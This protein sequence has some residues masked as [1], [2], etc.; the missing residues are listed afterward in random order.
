MSAYGLRLC[1]LALVG[2][3]PQHPGMSG[4][5]PEGAAAFEPESPS[6][7]Y[8]EMWGAPRRGGTPIWQEIANH[9]VPHPEMQGAPLGGVVLTLLERRYPRHP[10]MPGVPPRG[11]A[12]FVCAP[13]HVPYPQWMNWDGASP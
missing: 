12:A 3:Y 4:V 11:A 2:Y 1:S 13:L 8:P 10:W 6:V 7:P 9:Y 5:P